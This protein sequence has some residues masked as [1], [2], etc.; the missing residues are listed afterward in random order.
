MSKGTKLPDITFNKPEPKVKGA[1]GNR[2][3]QQRLPLSVARIELNGIHRTIQGFEHALN[4][5]VAIDKDY[6]V[7]KLHALNHQVSCLQI[8]V[9]KANKMGMVGNVNSTQVDN[10]KNRVL[11]IKSRLEATL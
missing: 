6:A 1:K 10:V 5:G 2:T 4:E 3:N 9:K 11:E 7:S 8:A